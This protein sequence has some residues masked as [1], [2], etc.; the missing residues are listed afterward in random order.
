MY[1]VNFIPYYFDDDFTKKFQFVKWQWMG[2][3]RQILMIEQHRV[4]SKIRLHVCA[5]WSCSTLF[6][7][8]TFANGWISVRT[9]WILWQ[10]FF[11]IHVQFNPVPHMPILGFS[12]STANTDMIS[13]I[14][15]NWDT[16]FWTSR[17]H[18]GK[19][20][21]CWLW[22]ISSFPMFNPFTNKPW[23]LTHMS[24]ECSVRYCGHSPA[25]GVRL[26]VRPSTICLLTL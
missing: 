4:Q 3:I 20:I 2:F 16:I 9:I 19:I 6:A 14:L 12:N 15:T 5:D 24:T 10:L 11:Y 22:A 8:F 23:F 18:C 26:S 13:K 21:N 17:K 25:V 1:R 7:E